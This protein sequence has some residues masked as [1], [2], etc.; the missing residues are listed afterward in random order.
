MKKAIAIVIVAVSMVLFVAAA[1]LLFDFVT[2]GRNNGTQGTS[3]TTEIVVPETPNVTDASYFNFTAHTAQNSDKETYTYYTISAKSAE[4]LPEI[5]VIPTEYNGCEVRFIDTKG[6]A[7]A[8]IKKLYLSGGLKSTGEKAFYGCDKLE[9]IIVYDSKGFFIGN[10]AFEWCCGL[11]KISFYNCELAQFGNCSFKDCRKLKEFNFF[12]STVGIIDK[13]AFENCTSLKSFCVPKSTARI[14]CTAF[15]GCENL[16]VTV[17]NEN[18]NFYS[19]GDCLISKSN[20]GLVWCKNIDAIPSDGSVTHIEDFTFLEKSGVTEYVMPDFITSI[21]SGDINRKSGGFINCQ[22]L[23]K[24]VFSKNLKVIPAN[25]C[26]G[27]KKLQKIDLGSV[28]AIKAGAFDDCTSLNIIV[29]SDKLEE[30]ESFNR[31]P[32]FTEITIPKGVKSIGSCFGG[33]ENLT[34]VTIPDG[35]EKI[36]GAFNDCP[37]LRNTVI[38]EGVKE[39]TRSFSEC[40]YL[41]EI[42]IPSTVNSVLFSFSN[43]ALL[44]KAELKNSGRIFSSFQECTELTEITVPDG[45]NVLEYSFW[46]CTNLR[47]VTLPGGITVTQSSFSNCPLLMDIYYQGT[48]AEWAKINIGWL[49]G[50]TA[51]HCKDGDIKLDG[52]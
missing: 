16:S 27:L 19:T 32:L 28:V 12:V 29:W 37:R 30:L 45:V 33:C 24:I 21:G 15:E 36:S 51:V 31:C 7:G 18:E 40:D 26:I 38:P 13:N 2:A 4:N 44:K 3:G 35:V 17:D 22:S 1:M 41:T 39:I 50:T 9:E 20:K 10:S 42:T 46:N 23:E 48:M 34:K 6:F 11:E 52:K 25:A 43:C 5:L 49:E 47:K 8:K 14:D